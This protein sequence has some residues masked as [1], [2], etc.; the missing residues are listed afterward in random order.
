MFGART[1]TTLL[2]FYMYLLN[3]KDLL[4]LCFDLA[5]V[6]FFAS[7]QNKRDKMKL[8]MIIHASFFLQPSKYLLRLQASFS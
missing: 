5:L 1:T 7:I 3:H 2:I 6:V 8:Q 4:N